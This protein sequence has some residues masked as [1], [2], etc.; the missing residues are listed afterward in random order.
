DPYEPTPAELAKEAN[1]YA[2]ADIKDNDGNVVVAKGKLLDGFSQ[3]KDDG[4]T[5]SGVWIFCGSWTEQGNQMARRDNTDTSGG[6]G[7]TPNWAWSWPANR[8]ILYNRASADVNG[9]PLN[10][11]RKL[12]EWNGSQWVGNDVPD[13]TLTAAPELNTG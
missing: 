5:S 10:P 11:H 2:L 7:V 12:I 4:T 13:Y 8:R 9:K 1:G 3:L 6:L